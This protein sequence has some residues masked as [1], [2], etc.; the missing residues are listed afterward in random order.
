MGY[1]YQ[2]LNGASGGVLT[3][4]DYNYVQGWLTTWFPHVLIIRGQVLQ[5]S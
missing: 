1:S 4:W 3:V 2:H 5:T